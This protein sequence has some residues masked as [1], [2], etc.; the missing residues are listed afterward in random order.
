MITNRKTPTGKPSKHCDSS[1]TAIS[2]FTVVVL[3]TQP[4]KW[5]LMW[6]VK[7][8]WRKRSNNRTASPKLLTFTYFH[9][10]SQE[11][12]QSTILEFLPVLDS[13][14]FL[15]GSSNFS[16]A[17]VSRWFCLQINRWQFPLNRVLC[18]DSSQISHHCSLF[19]V[20]VYCNDESEICK[21]FMVGAEI[22]T[23]NIMYLAISVIYQSTP[24]FLY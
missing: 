18:Y 22:G 15:R 11:V 7:K 1:S 16:S 10:L 2:L 24:D 21:L 6:E 23:S 19:Q 4:L 8:P 20:S 13:A 3:Q 14:T 5:N 17:C 9:T 12:R